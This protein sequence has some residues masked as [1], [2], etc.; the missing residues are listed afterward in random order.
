MNTVSI[1]CIV[2]MV[3]ISVTFISTFLLDYL[4]QRKGEKTILIEQEP[5]YTVV[6]VKDNKEYVIAKHLTKEQAQKEQENTSAFT[7]LVKED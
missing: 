1:I 4:K 6:V 7:K 2:I 5:R 3:V